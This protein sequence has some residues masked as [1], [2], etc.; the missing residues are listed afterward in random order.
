[1]SGVWIGECLV[2]SKVCLDFP[3][4]GYCSNTQTALSKQKMLQMSGV[5]I[6]INVL[7]FK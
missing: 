7:Y 4:C 5:R 2:F 3:K 1:M 6:G